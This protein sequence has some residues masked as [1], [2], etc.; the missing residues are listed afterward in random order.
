MADNPLIQAL[1]SKVQGQ[2][3]DPQALLDFILSHYDLTPKGEDE[4]EESD[5]KPDMVMT[6]E[7]HAP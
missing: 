5:D 4:G 7:S 6:Q 3:A 1:R 2:A